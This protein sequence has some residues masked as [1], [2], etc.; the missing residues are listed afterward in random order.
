MLPQTPRVL[1]T[2][3]AE[4]TEEFA[5][6]LGKTLTNEVLILHGELGAGKTT[7]VRGLAR[8]LEVKSRIQSPTFTYQRIHE[9]RTKLYHFDCYRLEKRDLLLEEEVEDAIHRHDGVVVI[10]WP[11]R[12]S[13]ALPHERIDI[14]FV[15]GSND[16]RTLTLVQSDESDT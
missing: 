11:E 4:E 12:V 2:K 14:Y 6:E 5:E 3:S 10:E 7:F 15:H 1:V 8:G 13:E 9:G 16:E